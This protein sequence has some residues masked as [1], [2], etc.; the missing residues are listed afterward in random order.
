MFIYISI[1]RQTFEYFALSSAAFCAASKAKRQMKSQ[2]KKRREKEKQKVKDQEQETTNN[3]YTYEKG[4][5]KQS[6]EHFMPQAKHVIL[7]IFV[8]AQKLLFLKII[9]FKNKPTATATTT[10]GVCRAV[11]R[12]LL[13]MM[14]MMMMI[15]M[16]TL[17]IKDKHHRSIC[18]ICVDSLCFSFSYV[19]SKLNEI[20]N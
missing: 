11:Q 19:Y 9:N 5:A 7:I 4:K 2:R 12:M 14:I 3:K 10:R 1:C 18:R 17:A 13:L 15:L 16:G 6:E 20:K 8:V